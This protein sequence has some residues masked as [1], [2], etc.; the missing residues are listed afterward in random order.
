MAAEMMHKAQT[1]TGFAIARPVLARDREAGISA[2]HRMSRSSLP[3]RGLSSF[4]A[5]GIMWEREH[6]AR[7]WGLGDKAGVLQHVRLQPRACKVTSSQ[8]R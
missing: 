3:L 4:A 8:D 1:A 7:Q 5:L 6:E 2:A